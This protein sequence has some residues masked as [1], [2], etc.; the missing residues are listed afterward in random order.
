MAKTLHEAHARRWNQQILLNS[1]LTTVFSKRIQLVLYLEE[2]VVHTNKE[3]VL[4]IDL[5]STTVVHLE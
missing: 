5:V 3:L 2:L 4:N 1:V